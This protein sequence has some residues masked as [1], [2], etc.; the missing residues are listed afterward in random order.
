V[1]SGAILKGN[2]EKTTKETTIQT[3][4]SRVAAVELEK[5]KL[6]MN[7]KNSGKLEFLS[8]FAENECIKKLRN[9]A[10]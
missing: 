8:N 10:F 7:F 6:R 2:W 5:W 1:S 9:T 4:I 3:V